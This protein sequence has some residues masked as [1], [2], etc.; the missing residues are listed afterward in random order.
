VSAQVHPQ[1]DRKAM[2]LLDLFCII[3]AIGIALML[4]LPARKEW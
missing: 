3:P 2:T 1:S 4:L